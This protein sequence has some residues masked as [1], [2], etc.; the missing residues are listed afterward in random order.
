[1]SV[2]E[3]PSC[4]SKPPAHGIA[5]HVRTRHGRQARL[6]VRS[7]HMTKQ[8]SCGA[9]ARGSSSYHTVAASGR[10]QIHACA[11]PSAKWVRFR[12]SQIVSPAWLLCIAVTGRSE[13]VGRTQR[14]SCRRR[15][16]SRHSLLCTRRDPHTPNSGDDQVG[17][18]D[19]GLWVSL[20]CAQL[21]KS[22]GT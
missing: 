1:M 9:Q 19:T 8:L 22:A 15:C 16:W 18:I 14:K 7:N 20:R 11:A 10:G 17:H 3:H 12:P 21:A 5:R 6:S 2:P 13:A 4:E